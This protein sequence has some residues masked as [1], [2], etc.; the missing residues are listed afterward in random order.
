ML[1]NVGPTEE[2]TTVML[3]S[4]SSSRTHQIALA[5]R[6]EP[7]LTSGFFSSEPPRCPG[8]PGHHSRL[9]APPRPISW[10]SSPSSPTGGEG[11]ERPINFT[12]RPGGLAR[13]RHKTGRNS[14]HRGGRWMRGAALESSHRPCHDAALSRYHRVL[15]K[16]GAKLELDRAICYS[17]VRGT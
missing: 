17:I 16:A 1:Q 7:F 15:G 14:T 6:V 13:V 12:S 9:L 2:S 4:S 3:P 11:C 5:Y 10:P 8:T